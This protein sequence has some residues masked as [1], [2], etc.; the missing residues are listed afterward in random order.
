[1]K[2]APSFESALSVLAHPHVMH[3]FLASSTRAEFLP[4]NPRMGGAAKIP[5][6]NPPAVLTIC[7]ARR[8][9]G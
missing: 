1:M 6:L 5:N 7:T 2:G 3:A 4:C 9:V 8:E